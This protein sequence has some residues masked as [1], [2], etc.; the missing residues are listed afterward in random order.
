MWVLPCESFI[1]HALS[2]DIMLI[3]LSADHDRPMK[4]STYSQHGAALILIRQES[5]AARFSGRLVAHQ[6]DV[7]DFTV[8]AVPDTNQMVAESRCH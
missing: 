8:P 4:S 1:H 3:L 7:H 6:I 5:K 2:H